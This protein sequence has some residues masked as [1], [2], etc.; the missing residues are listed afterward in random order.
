MLR[1]FQR[2]LAWFRPAAIAMLIL[3]VLTPSLAGFTQSLTRTSCEMACCKK[4][5]GCHRS[6]H[7]HAPNGPQWD[8]APS[9]P[10]SCTQR[11]GM[12]GSVTPVLIVQHI[13]MRPLVAAVFM[14]VVA[15]WSLPGT[16]ADFALFQRPPPTFLAI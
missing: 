16:S 4:A 9:C 2:Q 13:E 15:Y 11:F 14:R 8:T 12:P 6:E 10:E 7:H 3:A 1:L 5:A